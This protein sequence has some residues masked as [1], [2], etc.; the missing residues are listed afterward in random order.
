MDEGYSINTVNVS[1]I[2]W[3]ALQN[4][5]N[6]AS[7]TAGKKIPRLKGGSGRI[8]FPTDEEQTVLLKELYTDSGNYDFTVLLLNTGAR[9]QE[10][11]QLQL[12]QIDHVNGTI[13]IHRSKG[14]TDTTMKMSKAVV[15]VIARRM[16]AAEQP[17]LDGQSMHG[18]TGNGALFP[19]RSQEHPL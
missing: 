1:I 4:Y 18:R 15:E 9:E 7:F 13:T 3:N 14:G 19:E 6:K 11:A 2:Y 12:S 16:V 8:R 5:C 10:V 17:L